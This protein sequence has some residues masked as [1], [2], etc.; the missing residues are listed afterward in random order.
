MQRYSQQVHIRFKSAVMSYWLW[1][2]TRATQLAR[3]LQENYLSVKGTCLTYTAIPDSPVTQFLIQAALFVAD[4]QKVDALS[5]LMPGMD[6]P[7]GE[8]RQILTTHIESEDNSILYPIRLFLDEPLYI[9]KNEHQ[10]WVNHSPLTQAYDAAKTAYAEMTHQDQ[11]LWGQLNYLCSQLYLNSKHVRGS[12]YNADAGVYVSIIEFMKYYKTLDKASI[13]EHVQREIDTLCSVGGED[14]Y[15]GTVASCIANRR[16]ALLKAMTGNESVLKEIKP[17][18]QIIST[19]ITELRANLECAKHALSQSLDEG[20]YSGRDTLGFNTILLTALGVTF[21]IHTYADLSLF[22]TLHTQEITD[23][24]QS[25]ELREQV[26]AQLYPLDNLVMFTLEMPAHT[27]QPWLEGMEA[28]LSNV[29]IDNP[30]NLSAL[31]MSLDVEKFGLVFKVLGKGIQSSRDFM[32]LLEGLTSEQRIAVYHFLND[33]LPHMI[34]SAQDLGCVLRYLTPEQITIFLESLEAK[35][36]HIIQS[37]EDFML[38]VRSLT[39]DRCTAVYEFLKDA[40]SEMIQSNRDLNHV[41]RYLTPAQITTVLQSLKVKVTQLIT[42]GQQFCFILEFLT[43]QGCT[44]VYDYLKAEL[45]SMVKFGKDFRAIVHYLTPKQRAEVLS[46]VSTQLAQIIKS[47][48]DCH[49]ILHCLTLEDRSAILLLFTTKLANV[50]QS[51]QDL[52]YVLRYLTPEQIIAFIPL[53]NAD[54]IQSIDYL[55]DALAILDLNQKI[56]VCVALNDKLPNILQSDKDLGRLL[57]SLRLHE[58]NS[59]FKPLKAELHR[60]INSSQNLGKVLQLLSVDKFEVVYRYAESLMPEEEKE[61]IREMPHLMIILESIQPHT[62]SVQDF[63]SAVLREDVMAAD[64][65][66]Q[67]FNAYPIHTPMAVSLAE[68]MVSLFGSSRPVMTS[69]IP[70]VWKNKISSVLPHDSVAQLYKKILGNTPRQSNND[71]NDG[72]TWPYP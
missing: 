63:V 39:R 18:E 36:T 71:S 23:V 13:P 9:T 1:N 6:L 54:M 14:T 70:L 11:T 25:V 5:V 15:T 35:L 22:Y 48:E 8:V 44:A 37:S 64:A 42:S 61:L 38:T 29:F 10:R 3:L 30:R 43:Q 53:L 27:L 19:R 21:S 58:I 67:R 26:I 33:D 7:D 45:P 32:M 49:H 2:G 47:G 56:A 72:P 51:G 57:Q 41:L 40:L 4:V 52:N 20:H 16:M 65:Q 24:L 62:R 66:I 46:S 55:L 60:I 17:D 12:E 28:N 31:L 34:Q 68:K 69:G 59:F 50:I